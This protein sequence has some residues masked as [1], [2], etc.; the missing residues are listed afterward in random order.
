LKNLIKTT[1]GFWKLEDDAAQSNATNNSFKSSKRYIVPAAL[2][3]IARKV[4]LRADNISVLKSLTEVQIVPE[5][6]V[7]RTF[8]IPCQYLIVGA[9]K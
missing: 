1:A 4:N 5:D 3:I 9:I 2:R 6:E 7:K 8:R